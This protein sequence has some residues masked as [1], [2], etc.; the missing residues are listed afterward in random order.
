MKLTFW[1]LVLSIFGLYSVANAQATN[2][3]SV[4][5]WTTTNTADQVQVDRA[6]AATGPFTKLS[7]VPAGVLTYTD[8]TNS[9]GVTSCYRV[10][11]FTASGNGPSSNVACKTFPQVPTVAPVLSPIQ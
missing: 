6:P 7:T 2:L 3:T 8:A 9:P 10:E 11:H 5:T 4:L 1:L